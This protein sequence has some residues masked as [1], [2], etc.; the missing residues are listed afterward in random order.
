MFC[1][2]SMLAYKAVAYL[3]C[4]TPEGTKYTSLMS[5]SKVAP[6]K[7]QTM[8]RLELLAA[9]LGAQLSKYISKAAL[10]NFKP[11]QTVLWS[12]SQITVSWISS[13]EA[14]RQQFIRHRVRLINDITSPSAW[15][16]CP[17]TSN[18]ADIIIRGVE[19]KA[20][21]SKQ[22]DWNQGP[23]WLLRPSQEWPSNTIGEIQDTESTIDTT[24]I[25]TN[26][27]NT[28]ENTNLL[29]VIDI[30]RYS[31]LNKTLRITALVIRFIKKL[32]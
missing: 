3:R 24:S 25:I 20:V 5:K 6:L 12:D 30:T 1:D 22:G 28:Q 17:T 21:I 13:T 32:R 10:Q 18:P 7:Q 27:T 26:L 4:N 16:F 8:P 15:R 23:T 14:L 29:N 11:F 2:S 31:T 9:L 19:A